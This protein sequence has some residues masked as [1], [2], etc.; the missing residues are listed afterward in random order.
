MDRIKINMDTEYV[1]DVHE[2]QKQRPAPACDNPSSPRY[3]DAGDPE[4]MDYDV[5]FK[6]DNM[7]GL[8]SI[9]TELENQ[10]R[11]EFDEAVREHYRQKEI[12]SYMIK[13]DV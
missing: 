7:P 4:D 12:D 5:F 3:A 2:Y 13:E 11:E 10:Y 6:I 8:V 1:I 9:P